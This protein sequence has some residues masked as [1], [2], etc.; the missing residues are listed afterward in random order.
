MF[1][2]FRRYQT[3][4]TGGKPRVPRKV[5]PRARGVRQSPTVSPGNCQAPN[6]HT[7]PFGYLHTLW[8]A[9]LTPHLSR[10]PLFLY[11]SIVCGF[12]LC[13][14]VCARAFPWPWAHVVYA[15]SYSR[16]LGADPAQEPARPFA[17][18]H[19]YACARGLSH[20]WAGRGLE[21]GFART[22]GTAINSH[23]HLQLRLL[24][25]KPAQRMKMKN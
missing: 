1:L 19:T 15:G 3:V 22:Q 9:D 17:Q 13:A 25:W 8:A 21:N 18:A 16:R 20:S 24:T 6:L 12:F 5:R 2:S 4:R 14:C 11:F 7:H 10:R 23:Q